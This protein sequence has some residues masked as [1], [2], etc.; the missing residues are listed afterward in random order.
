MPLRTRITI[1]DSIIALR[2][3]LLIERAL[4]SVQADRVEA[5]TT[6][7]SAPSSN[8]HVSHPYYL[9]EP[10]QPRQT[11]LDPSFRQ[12]AAIPPEVE[13][14]GSGQEAGSGAIDYVMADD[15][16]ADGQSKRGAKQLR[17]TKRAQQNRAAQVRPRTVM[18]ER[19]S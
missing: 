13:D 8:S 10:P 7:G 5:S 17:E 6:S 12:A 19:P 11:R 15:L 4:S 18:I 2:E 16:D 3:H 14:G 9:P 1:S